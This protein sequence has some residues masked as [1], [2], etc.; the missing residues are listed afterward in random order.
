MKILHII[1][2]VDPR[3][4]GPIEGILRQ[5]EATRQL[6]HKEIAS[7]DMADA[8]YLDGF[9]LTV[10]ALGESPPPIPLKPFVH[11]RYSRKLIPWL[12]RNVENF[13]AVIV[14]GLWNFAACS[15]SRVLPRKRTPYFV[16]THGMLD[17][18]FRSAYPIKHLG[19]QLSWWFVEG[20]LLSHA[21]AVL[22]TCDAERNLARGVFLGHRYIEKV[23]PYGTKRPAMD[24]AGQLSAFAEAAPAV[25]GRDFLL[26][27][28][29][30]HRKKGVDLLIDAF[31]DIVAANPGLDLVIAG[32]DH[33]D[34]GPTLRARIQALGL[35]SRIHWTGMLQGAAKWGAFRAAQAFVLPSHQENF[36]I[37]VA[38]ALACGAPVLIT[39][40]VN[41][42]RE[43]EMAGA[44]LVAG[45][46][47]AGIRGLLLEWIGKSPA[48][49]AF[50]REAAVTL[51]NEKFDLDVVGASLI[52]QIK[53]LSVDK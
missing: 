26:Y 7:L 4:G 15:A 27:M 16:F 5:D 24:E 38:E 47:A 34:T 17:P 3:R 14:N 13:D 6:A 53:T 39:D 9:P 21:S 36:G 40:K 31:A 48:D 42:W 30:I 19:K 20:R 35:G 45:D 50:M 11:Y 52:D 18:W 22:F 41:I 49:R 1:D 32:P 23:V 33:D 29:R 44:G 37:V 2:S 12:E 25:R 46:T 8:P 28:G 43:V 10:H 51:F